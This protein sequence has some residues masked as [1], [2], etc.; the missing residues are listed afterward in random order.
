M[1][2]LAAWEVKKMPKK[3]SKRR[4]GQRQGI[5]PGAG[6]LNFVAFVVRPWRYTN[7]ADLCNRTHPPFS[8]L[9]NVFHANETENEE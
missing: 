9:D 5:A 2:V 7:M 4:R 6:T 1:L 3:E 8:P